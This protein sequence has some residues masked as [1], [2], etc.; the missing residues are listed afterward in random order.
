MNTT[1]VTK[2]ADPAKNLEAVVAQ[3]QT[4][5]EGAVGDVAQAIATSRGIKA[6]R[7]ALTD[8]VMADLMSLMNDALG[9]KTDRSDPNKGFYNVDV[10]RNCLISGFMRGAKVVGNEINIIASQCYLTK[11]FYERKLGQL[12]HIRELR[13]QIGTAV[14]GE[15]T[16][17]MPAKASWVDTRDGQQHV[18]E[19]AMVDG[20]DGRIQVNSY[21]TSSPDEL[22]GKAESKLF[23]R[24]YKQISGVDI[25]EMDEPLEGSVVP[26]SQLDKPKGIEGKAEDDSKSEREVRIEKVPAAFKRFNVTVEMLQAKI[27][28]PLDQ[29]TDKD[30]DILSG[31]YDVILKGDKKASEIFT[32][33]EITDGDIRKRFFKLKSMSG[34][35]KAADELIERGADEDIVDALA[36]EYLDNLKGSE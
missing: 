16:A 1:A 2:T 7:A 24:I 3:T 12:T 26:A 18:Y 36:N 29:A 4:E 15:K 6:I 10:V 34:I 22:H 19:C 25:P 30:L 8:E 28:K 23:R 31:A 17:A 35:R 13:W 9:F 32:F 27:G 33:P 20:F 14:K 11:E 21:A 5:L